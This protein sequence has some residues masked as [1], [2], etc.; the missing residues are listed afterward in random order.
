MCWLRYFHASSR[1]MFRYPR[2]MGSCTLNRCSASLMS[3]RRSGVERGRYA[4]TSGVWVRPGTTS[5]LPHS[6]RGSVRIQPPT[7]LAVLLS[8]GLRRLGIHRRYLGV[9]SNMSRCTSGDCGSK[10]LSGS[11]SPPGASHQTPRVPP[12]LWPVPTQSLCHPGCLVS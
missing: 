6:D 2:T 8:P 12:P 9:P 11:S 10:P 3:G 1:P 7:C 5:K 4:L